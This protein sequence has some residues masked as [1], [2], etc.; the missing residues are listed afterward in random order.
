MVDPRLHSML[1]VLPKVDLHRHLEGSIRLETLL[2]IAGKYGISLPTQEAHM[3]RPHVQMMPDDPPTLSCFLSKFAVLRGFFRSPEVVQRITTE[4]IADAAADNVRY[5]ELRFTPFALANRMYYTIPQAVSWVCEAAQAAAQTYGIQVGLIVSMNRHEPVE[6]GLQ[7][8][9]AALQYQGQGVVGIDLAGREVGCSARPFGPLFLEAQRQ[10][11]GI[12]IHAG[13]WSGPANIQDAVENMYANRIGHGVRVIEDSSM[14]QL[15][16][17]YGIVLE[18]CLTSN[19]HTGAVENM[20][21]HPLLDLHQLHVPV[22]IN[23]DDPAISGIT[24]TDEYVLAVETMG[25]SL[26]DLHQSILTA[27]G[28]AFLPGLRK[29]RLLRSLRQELNQMIGVYVEAGDNR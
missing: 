18:V 15:L 23:T 21:Y 27:A 22:T 11:L 14:I 16:R 25:F 2:E 13:E 17:Q 24:L 9:E 8:F 1:Q 20:T 7:A 12:T 28:A 3:L 5:L 6:L 26:L 19:W 4:V 29:Q 10:G